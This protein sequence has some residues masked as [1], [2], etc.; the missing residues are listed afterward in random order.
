M[1]GRVPVKQELMLSFSKRKGP[2]GQHVF[3]RGVASLGKARNVRLASGCFP[4]ARAHIAAFAPLRVFSAQPQC[5]GRLRV[6]A[7]EPLHFASQGWAQSA[8]FRELKENRSKSF[9]SRSNF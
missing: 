6:V 5:F 3:A 7:T 8:L 4:R 9:W 1:R 2:G